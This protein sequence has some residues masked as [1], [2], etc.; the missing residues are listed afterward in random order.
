MRV[1]ILHAEARKP[2]S[3][4]ARRVTP[5]VVKGQAAALRPPRIVSIEHFQHGH[6]ALIKESYLKKV[7]QA[8]REIALVTCYYSDHKAVTL[9]IDPEL[10]PD[11]NRRNFLASSSFATAGVAIPI[12]F[13]AKPAFAATPTEPLINT[14]IGTAFVNSAQN[15][16]TK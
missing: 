8:E 10:E 2:A 4:K 14:S 15:L 7:A 16:Y 3:K 11:L 13:K 5:P 6:A 9:E 12:I 1:T